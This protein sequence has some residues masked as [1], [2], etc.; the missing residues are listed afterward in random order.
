M[1]V[2]IYEDNLLWGPRLLKT[3][4]AFGHE[5]F[6]VTVAEPVEADV[7]IVNL[8]SSGFPVET[9]V[10]GLRQAGVKVIAHAG[11]KERELHAAG[12]DLGCDVLATNSEITHKLPQILEKLEKH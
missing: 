2:A 7:A 10:P 12:K 11:H 4:N 3:V 5:G 8:S 6:L 1:K 9:L